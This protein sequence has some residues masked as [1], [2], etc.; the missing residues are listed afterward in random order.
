MPP[1]ACVH[2]SPSVSPCAMQDF[3]K[4]REQYAASLASDLLVKH[5]IHIL[6]DQLLESNLVR[7]F[8]V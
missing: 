7:F 8:I 5:H 1:S 3:D 6:Y 2:P 4:A